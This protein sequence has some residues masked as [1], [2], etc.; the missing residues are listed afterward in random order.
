M[1][2]TKTFKDWVVATRP[3]SFPASAMPVIV[4]LAYLFWRQQDVNWLIGVW[5]LL[6]VVLFHAAGNTWSDYSDYQKGVDRD[7]TIGGTSIVSG[8]FKA[9]EIKKLAVVLAVVAS[10]SGVALVMATGWT[11]LCFGVAGFLLA[12]LYPFLKYRA[13]GDLDI[14]LTYSLL[15]I[16][17]TSFVST[18]EIHLET[19]WLTVPV[20]LIT[21]GILHVNNLRDIEHDRRAGIKT[22]AM[23]LGAKVSVGLYCFELLF[24]FVWVVAGVIA[25]VF[26]LPSLLVVAALKLAAG[27]IRMALEYRKKGMQALVSVDEKTAQLQL[28]FSLL[29]AITFIVSNLVNID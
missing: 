15:P 4:T 5:T 19:L 11:T 27:N 23:Q 10:L 14:F 26:P 1:N 2:S 8:K 13:L 21:V 24:P 22:L 29:L 18:G 7:D 9:A 6:N 20:G 28:L 12:A 17:G 16:L 3:W 25:G